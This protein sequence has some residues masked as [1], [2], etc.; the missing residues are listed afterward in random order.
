MTHHTNPKTNLAARRNRPTQ[1]EQLFKR[2]KTVSNFTDTDPW[3]VLRIM[4]EFTEGFEALVDLGPAVTIFGSART[5]PDHSQYKAAVEVARLLGEAGITI[6]TGGG[7]GIMEAGNKGALEAGTPSIGLNVELPF[8]QGLNK[9][10][11]LSLEF[12]YFFVRKTMFVKYA[13]AFVIFPG[14]FGTMDELF[15]AVT[16]IQTGK[17]QNFP[18]ILF[19]KAYWQGLVDWL[20]NTMLAQGKIAAADLDL[21]ILT[22]SPEEVHDIIVSVFQ[23]E[24]WRKEQEESARQKTRQVFGPGFE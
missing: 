22:D 4:G 24:N 12:H 20:K 1:D 6:I 7:P 11:D 9:Y 17:V 13:Q 18:V 15:E 21:L 3:R 2:S 14:G 8:E 23:E 16:L 5:K 10:V 19:D